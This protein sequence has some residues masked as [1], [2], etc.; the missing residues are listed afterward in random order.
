MGGLVDLE[1][2]GV[3]PRTA[4][5]VSVAAVLC[6]WW[7]YTFVTGE[8]DANQTALEALRKE[9]SAVLMLLRDELAEIG[10]GL[11]LQ[12]EQLKG[13]RESQGIQL[14]AIRSQQAAAIEALRTQ[15]AMGLDALQKQVGQQLDFIALDQ[16]GLKSDMR[17]LEASTQADSR[18]LQ[19][20]LA[21]LR[22][23]PRAKADGQ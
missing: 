6:A 20:E 15:T 8:S 7:L 16:A 23:N 9:H 4:S 3:S 13:L 11:G 12:A 18:A 2:G 21:A 22:N 5:A 1:K 17:G 14:E 10:D 19:A